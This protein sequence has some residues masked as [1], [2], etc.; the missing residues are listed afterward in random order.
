MA[1]WANASTMSGLTIS[2]MSGRLTNSTAGTDET[3]TDS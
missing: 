1:V 3:D 2:T